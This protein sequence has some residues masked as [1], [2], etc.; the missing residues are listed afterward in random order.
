MR[1]DNK[2]KHILFA[3][4]ILLLCFSSTTLMLADK[5]YAQSSSSQEVNSEQP[6]LEI[7]DSVQATPERS[8]AW[9]SSTISDLEGIS[10]KFRLKKAWKN[11]SEEEIFPAGTEIIAQIVR[12]DNLGNLNMNVILIK[13]GKQ[14]ISVP[15]NT[16]VMTGKDGVPLIAK[17]VQ[18]ENNSFTRDA[19]TVA[20]SGVQAVLDGQSGNFRVKD[21]VQRVVNRRLNSTSGV[22][23]SSYFE[24]KKGTTVELTLNEDFEF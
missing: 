15:E 21:G 1:T 16:I 12:V 22:S 20:G 13:S 23:S 7:G 2:L 5:A 19:R 4:T 17:L 3:G 9:T 10:Y 11:S 8:I 6:K 18:T 14:K 24:L